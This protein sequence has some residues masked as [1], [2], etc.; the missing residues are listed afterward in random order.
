[1]GACVGLTV[2]ATATQPLSS[3][4]RLMPEAKLPALRKSALVGPV[5]LPYSLGTLTKGTVDARIR[6]IYCSI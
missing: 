2:N 1:V 3:D 6:W 4:M 5:V